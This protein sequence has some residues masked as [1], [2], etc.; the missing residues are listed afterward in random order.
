MR[1]AIIY[2]YGTT[3]AI[4]GH[5]SLSPENIKRRYQ[6]IGPNGVE[7]DSNLIELGEKSYNKKNDE[8]TIVGEVGYQNQNKNVFILPFSYS[9]CLDHLEHRIIK[10]IEELITINENLIKSDCLEFPLFEL[11][12]ATTEGYNLF[13]NGA[14]FESVSFNGFESTSQ[15]EKRFKNKWCCLGHFYIYIIRTALKNKGYDIRDL[16]GYNNIRG[17][18]FRKEDGTRVTV[19]A[20]AG[21]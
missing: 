1:K 5:N 12:S 9:W 20:D 4:V 14:G 21:M 11:K 7:V 17:E 6:L 3:K 15:K 8:G 13:G 18:T 19:Y 10:H 16:N 2:F